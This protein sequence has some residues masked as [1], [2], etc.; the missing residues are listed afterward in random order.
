MAFVEDHLIIEKAHITQKIIDCSWNGEDIKVAYVFFV[1]ANVLCV[2]VSTLLTV[3][4]SPA[5]TGSG[6]AETMGI[7]NGL[8]LDGVLT[9]KALLVKIV[10]TTFAV[11]GGLC[12]GKEGPLLHVGAI[13]GIVM[14]YLPFD[15][16]RILQ[17]DV[18]KR[19]MVAAG[20]AA[21]VAAAFGS[22]IGGALFAY[23]ISKPNTFWTFTMLW[24]V[25]FSTSMA[26]VTISTLT[27]F[28]KATPLGL[29][30]TSILKF[31]TLD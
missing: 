21:G 1:T 9:L 3:Y 30:D 20:G 24:R 8:N 29:S 31:G 11:S 17:N 7:L 27:A 23:E 13:I 16:V 10:G 26:V 2:L 15:G 12:I 6:V 14:C 18:V 5:A 25:F 28:E 19:Q 22:P 4:V